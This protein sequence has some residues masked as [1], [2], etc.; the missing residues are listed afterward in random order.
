MLL[1]AALT[2]SQGEQ[3]FAEGTL[4]NP[5]G[6]QGMDGLFR[7]RSDGTNERGLA[8]MQIEAGAAKV[9]SPAPKT[10]AGGKPGL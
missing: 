8:V 10:F 9:V 6:F 7:F 2:Q 4:T 3:R 1:T 5:S